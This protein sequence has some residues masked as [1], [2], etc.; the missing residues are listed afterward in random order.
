MTRRRLAGWLDCVGGVV[1]CNAKFRTLL[2]F[3]PRE[4]PAFLDFL[5]DG[6]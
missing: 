3:A 5:A 1:A 4:T 2:G 6:A